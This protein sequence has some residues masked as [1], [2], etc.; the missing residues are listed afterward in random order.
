VFLLFLGGPLVVGGLLGAIFASTARR[1]FVLVLAGL[2]LQ[3]LL[4]VLVILFATPTDEGEQCHECEEFFGR[5][6]QPVIFFWAF[7]NFLAWLVG[8]SVGGLARL[9]LR[10]RSAA[11]S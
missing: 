9:V 2:A 11:V 10:R 4:L 6:I 1:T 8:L 3:V 7:F 5:W